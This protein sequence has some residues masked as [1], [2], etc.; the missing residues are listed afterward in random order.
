MSLNLVTVKLVVEMMN[1]RQAPGGSSAWILPEFRFEVG[2]TRQCVEAGKIRM[3][4]KD[5]DLIFGLS[6]LARRLQSEDH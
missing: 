1:T 3:E 6:K 4:S 2:L 5:L